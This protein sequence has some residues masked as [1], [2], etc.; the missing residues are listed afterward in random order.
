MS[1]YIYF[2]N[3]KYVHARKLGWLHTC[4]PIASI[5]VEYRYGVVSLDDSAQFEVAK[6]FINVS[7]TQLLCTV[8][9]VRDSFY[10]YN[11]DEHSGHFRQSS[12]FG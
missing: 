4:G 9:M 10:R 6:L 8:S 12:N 5:D 11:F 1:R 2:D 3:W 7:I